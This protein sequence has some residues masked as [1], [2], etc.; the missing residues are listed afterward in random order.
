[1][2]IDINMFAN[3][4]PSGN[5]FQDPR[6][7]G[8]GN[9]NR[10]PTVAQGAQ[11]TPA[12]SIGEVGNTAAPALP[13]F[14][15]ISD[16]INQINA[17][18]AAAHQQSLANRIPGGTRL[19]QLS[20][21]AISD[22]LN[23]PRQFAEIDVPSAARALG[24]GVSGSPFAGIQ[25]IQMSQNERIRRQG[26]GQ[27]FLTSALAR[28]PAAPI[29]DAQALAQFLGQQQFGAN[30]AALNRDFQARQA[31]LNRQLQAQLGLLSHNQPHYRSGSDY[32]PRLPRTSST[33]SFSAGIPGPS[34]YYDPS[35]Y[36]GDYDIPDL[37]GDD[38]DFT[39][40][41]DFNQGFPVSPE[42]DYSPEAFDYEYA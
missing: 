9:A 38:F 6:A 30:Q 1:M 10:N 16:L 39:P 32:G 13:Q 5:F 2:P 7:M 23:P 18:N 29:A 34:P 21:D 20:S 3:A 41:P 31:A 27:Q 33:G 15:E 42:Y 26:I 4:L 8:T 17:S 35:L 11:R 24:Q 28:N 37:A 25:G 12:T 40:Q 22:L 14:S 36:S 19:E